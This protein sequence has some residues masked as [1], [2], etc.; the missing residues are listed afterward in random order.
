MFYNLSI[1]LFK[2]RI[3]KINKPTKEAAITKMKIIENT[4]SL[5]N[6]HKL[7]SDVLEYSGIFNFFVKIK[8]SVPK[9]NYIG[10]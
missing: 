9:L 3:A 10:K 2:Y 8:I 7:K 5:H 1:N 4:P 6:N